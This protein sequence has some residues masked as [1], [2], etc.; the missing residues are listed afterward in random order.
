MPMP[1]GP[2]PATVPH[3]QGLTPHALHNPLSRNTQIAAGLHVRVPGL[4]SA[5]CQAGGGQT[6]AGSGLR[7]RRPSVRSFVCRRGRT[8]GDVVVRHITFLSSTFLSTTSTSFLVISGLTSRLT[9]HTL[10]VAQPH[11]SH[12]IHRQYTAFRSSFSRF[13]CSSLTSTPNSPPATAFKPTD[14]VCENLSDHGFHNAEP[15]EFHKTRQECSRP[16]ITS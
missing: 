14:A 11:T 12:H 5:R 3:K 4:S 1:L 6:Q 15:Q 2:C 9:N 8:P 16:Q 13:S 7:L 10:P